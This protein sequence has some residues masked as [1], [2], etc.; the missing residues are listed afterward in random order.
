MTSRVW[1]DGRFVARAEV[2]AFSH[3]VNY[4]CGVFDTV[5][6]YR[7]SEGSA[8]FRLDEHVKRLLAAVSFAGFDFPFKPNEIEAALVQV[9]QKNKLQSGYFRMNVFLAQEGLRVLPT[10]F[11]ASL[12]IMA[13]PLDYS[14]KSFSN[15]LSCQLTTRKKPPLSS[16]P[17]NVKFS[18][19]YLLSYLARK[20]ARAQGFDES[21]LLDSRGFVA[22]GT[23]QNLFIVKNGALLTPSK[24]SEIL[25]G[26]TRDSIIE[27]AKDLGIRVK[28]AD[29][30]VKQL[31]LADEVFLAGTAIEL[32]PVVRIGKKRLS[33]GPITS[34]LKAAY[35]DLVCGRHGFSKKWLTYL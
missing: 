8:F 11:K 1:Y 22:E 23:A 28:E 7:T 20:E 24:R 6:L 13:S 4:S 15:G 25:P 32:M 14:G 12:A 9:A 30:T 16:M 18:A 34:T 3:A 35:D 29:V 26:I 10:D 31:L 5:R 33:I 17:S 27:L 2:S 21:V 19:N